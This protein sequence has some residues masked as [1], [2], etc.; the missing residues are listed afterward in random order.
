MSDDKIAST[1]DDRITFQQF[2]AVLGQHKRGEIDAGEA[3]WL[4]GFEPEDG[5][6]PPGRY[7]YFVRGN[8]SHV[9]T[10]TD[11]LCKGVSKGGMNPRKYRISPTIVGKVCFNC[12]Q[13]GGGRSR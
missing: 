8:I 2:K 4:L 7:G 13:S 12:Q 11:T 1:W 10:G 3:W 6:P 5:H 9:W